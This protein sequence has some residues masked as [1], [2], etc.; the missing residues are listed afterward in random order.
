MKKAILVLV[1]ILA[2]ALAGCSGGGEKKEEKVSTPTPTPTPT[3]AQTS[4]PEK[5]P[6]PTETYESGETMPSGEAIR[7]LYEMYV[8]KK[9]LHG[10]YEITADGKTQTGEYWFYYDAANNQKLARMEGQSDQGK[11]VI[12][13]IEKYEGNTATT[14]LYMKGGQ[15]NQMGNCEWV[16]FTQTITVSPS[17]YEGIKD[18]PADQAAQATL[19]SQGGNVV[20]KFN[21]E[22]VDYDPSIFQPDGQ[23]CSMGSYIQR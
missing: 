16:S 6:T 7:T 10:T 5:T 20:E 4:I 21:I 15:Y 22:Y 9:M 19:V 2:L 1:V 17:D 11:S 8:N 23:V 3:P 18:E 14:T 13:V 12:I